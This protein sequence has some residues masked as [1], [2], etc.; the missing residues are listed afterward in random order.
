MSE[1][2]VLRPD[3]PAPGN[4]QA[5][6]TTRAGGVSAGACASLNLGSHVGDAPA[7][8]LENRRRLRAALALP[9]E[10][11]WL[12]Q[13]HG[14]QV[15]WHEQ[16]AGV[17][18][19]DA[20]VTAERGR[21]CAVLTADCLPVLFC[22]RHGTRVGVAHAGWR[23]LAAGVLEQTITALGVAPGELL[24]WLGPAIGPA[25]FEVGD[26]VR[27]EFLAQDAPAAAAF[28]RN[29]RGRWLADLYALARRRLQ[30]AGCEQV[31]GGGACTYTD[32]Q[33]FFSFRR[34]RH[35]GRMATLIW[36]S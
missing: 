25:V 14:T 5:A 17:P 28:V 16:S 8:V 15:V 33:R 21:V 24:A 12:S 7:A 35:A 30:L 26:E 34:D 13:V 18:V 3:W 11:L 9:G 10:P 1:L 32:A 36:L 29:E 31:S 20:A 2:E 22:D 6:A 27:A 23:G 19:A 4:V